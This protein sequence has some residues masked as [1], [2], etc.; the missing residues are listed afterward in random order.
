M[1]KNDASNGDGYNK[2]TPIMCLR[3]AAPHT[4]P[5]PSI[6]T[7]VFGGVFSM[8]AGYTFWPGVWV[9][10]LAVAVLMQSAVNTLN[11]WADF[12]KGTDTLENS[13]DPTDAV[14]V[15][16]NPNPKHVLALG[17]AYMAIGFSCGVVCLFI[18]GSI[19]PLIFGIIG[20]IVAVC[21]S[22][23]KIPISYLP[24]G[25]IF[26]GV[27]MGCLIPLA[28]ICV[29]AALTFPQNGLFDVFLQIDWWVAIY[30]TVPLI[31][32]VGMIMATQN[33]CDIER[34]EPSGRH[35]LPVVLGR[36]RSLMVYRVFV[37]LWIAVVLHIA[38]WFFPSG[39]WAS[40]VVLFFG[41]P[42]IR[43]T[44]VTNLSHEVRGPSMGAINKANLYINGAYI[45]AIT[46]SMIL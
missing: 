6:L 32:G 39:F 14:L 40:L 11:D 7:T 8:A 12:R 29:F 21:Y 41:L 9:L 44:L 36:K 38:F 18:C 46:V 4:W 13:D 34:D 35:T 10:L 17:I 26:S 37:L 5:G 20:V 28:D 1:T 15:Y 3:L 25:E 2:L 31:I 22:S 43:K 16:E 23:G 27:V 33:N 45:I 24:L 30:C 42:T 19:V